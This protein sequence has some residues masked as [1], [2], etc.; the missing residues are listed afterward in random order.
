M[1]RLDTLL[2]LIEF[3]HQT[4]TCRRLAIANCGL[5]LIEF[6]HQT[7]TNRPWHIDK[8]MLYLI[9]FLHQTTTSDV[10][11][12]AYYRLYLIEFLHQTTTAIPRYYDRYRLYL[13]EFLH[14]TTTFRFNASLAMSCILLNFYIKPQRQISKRLPLCVVS[15][16][17]STSNHNFLVDLQRVP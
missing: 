11:S 10:D 13:I 1:A 15:Y 8:K 16:W 5:Y 3:L 7:T 6:L 4:T 2:Y 17:I 14:Q 9:E 12:I